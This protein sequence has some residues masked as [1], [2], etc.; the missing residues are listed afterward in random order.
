MVPQ[1]LEKYENTF[2]YDA[3]GRLRK[4]GQSNPPVVRMMW[5]GARVRSG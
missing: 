1:K 4:F 5:Q 2:H 3:K